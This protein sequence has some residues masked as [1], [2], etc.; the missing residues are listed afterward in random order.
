MAVVLN[1]TFDG[2]D[3]STTIVDAAGH[4]MT[5]GGDAELDI[6]EKILGTAA[7]KLAGAGYVTTPDS[8]D[9]EVGTNDW[10]VRGWFRLGA[11]GVDQHIFMMRSPTNQQFIIR[12]TSANKLNFHV[13]VAG[14]AWGAGT[15]ITG[16]TTL[17][18]GVWYYFKL[19]KV[20][21]T[22]TLLLSVDRATFISQGTLAVGAGS[23][24]TGTFLVGF[25][26]AISDAPAVEASNRF[27]GW[28]DDFVFNN[29][30]TTAD[31]VPATPNNGFFNLL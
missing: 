10:E 18:T 11:V 27:T 26:T 23:G 19:K 9:W 30:A 1:L 21:E 22:V 5:A 8:A 25:G 7:L 16:A 24:P 17:I 15:D 28:I 3:G 14:A 20:G 2:T 4:T 6:A 13:E 29:G 31:V 12:V